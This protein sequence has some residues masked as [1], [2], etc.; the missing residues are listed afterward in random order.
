MEFFDGHWSVTVM[1]RNV[2]YDYY[3]RVAKQSQ[4]SQVQQ[5]KISQMG[6]MTAAGH[7]AFATWVTQCRNI[8]IEENKKESNVDEKLLLLLVD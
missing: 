2:D 1:N 5:A 7:S 8:E 6:A 3:Q 4:I